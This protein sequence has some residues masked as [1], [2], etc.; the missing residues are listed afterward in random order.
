MAAQVSGDDQDDAPL[1][2]PDRPLTIDDVPRLGS[3][4]GIAIGC[5]L[6]VALAI[7]AFWFV[8]GWFLHQ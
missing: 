6:L 2:T 1:E 8:R 7:G 4:S 3:G 5:G